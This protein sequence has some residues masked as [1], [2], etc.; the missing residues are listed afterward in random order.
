MLLVDKPC[1]FASHPAWSCSANAAT[2]ITAQGTV[3]AI[4]AA[5]RAIAGDSACCRSRHRSGYVAMR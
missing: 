1:P 3:D 4:L 2:P 5:R